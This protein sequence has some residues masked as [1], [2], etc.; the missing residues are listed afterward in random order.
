MQINIII[1][2]Q[3][4]HS[5]RHTKIVLIFCKVN[6]FFLLFKVLETFCFRQ[7]YKNNIILVCTNKKYFFQIPQI[8]GMREGRW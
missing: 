8:L 3:V 6:Y 5:I 2:D 4:Y 7:I 1:Y